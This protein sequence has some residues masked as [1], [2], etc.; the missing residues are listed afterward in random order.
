[1]SV[2]YVAGIHLL[3]RSRKAD[4]GACSKWG[5]FRLRQ[6]DRW[7][8]V[9]QA[10]SALLC[11]CKHSKW[12]LDVHVSIP[13]FKDS[14]GRS[15]FGVGRATGSCAINW[16]NY[17]VDSSLLHFTAVIRL[18]CISCV[19]SSSI[20]HPLLP[21][22][23]DFIIPIS[24]FTALD[25]SCKDRSKWLCWHSL[26]VSLGCRKWSLAVGIAGLF[27]LCCS[28]FCKILTQSFSSQTVRPAL[29]AN[30][31]PLTVIRSVFWSL[32]LLSSS[33]LPSTI[34]TFSNNISLQELTTD[35]LQAGP[36]N[37][38]CRFCITRPNLSFEKT[39]ASNG[40]LRILSRSALR[41]HRGI[42]MDVSHLRLFSVIS[43]IS[44]R[45]WLKDMRGRVCPSS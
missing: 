3:Y 25:W 28:L 9:C 24:L 15:S 29:K 39:L 5:V 6:T 12:L 8:T 18:S 35:Q 36:C 32:V 22:I 37:H 10:A 30:L 34:L 43:M 23:N 7:Q 40:M 13:I 31:V 27:P 44:G 1:M 4:N 20:L 26:P 42:V 38:C 14:K 17:W 33:S 16:Y 45:V 21:L 2:F 41:C 11:G 19:N